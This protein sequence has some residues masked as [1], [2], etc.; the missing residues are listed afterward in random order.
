MSDRLG[1]GQAL[2][3][4]ELQGRE[5]TV[6]LEANAGERMAIARSLD[7]ESLARLTAAITLRPWLDGVS[8][9][10][11]M[12]GAAIRLCGLSLEPFEEVLKDEFRLRLLPQGSPN[13]P[14][15]EGT[16]FVIDLEADDPPEEAG[17]ATVDL[18]AYV[19]EAFALA[20]DP[21]PR[22][23]GAVFVAPEE[24]VALSP[25]AALKALADRPKRP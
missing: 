10:G 20:L 1:W 3:W 15:Q 16:E 11:W 8:I 19:V 4:P 25:F 18:S 14:K 7:L 13:L 2:T 21:F 9:D 6:L 12:D 17:G 5:R 24:P 23:P 22:K